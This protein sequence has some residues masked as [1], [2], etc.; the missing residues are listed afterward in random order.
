MP[1]IIFQYN[2][3]DYSLFIITIATLAILAA[4]CGYVLIIDL[5]QKIKHK[6]NNSSLF[7]LLIIF[8]MF[9]GGF[10][11]T[12]SDYTKIIMANTNSNVRTK[13]IVVNKCSRSYR[14]GN[15][16][17]IAHNKIYHLEMP[18]LS[19]QPICQKLGR[20]AIKITYI[21][22]FAYDGLIIKAELGLG[23]P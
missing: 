22:D 5:I 9:F 18:F 20:N 23:Q 4:I 13:I 8:A 17:I 1:E 12:T 19:F 16:T 11:A 21:P 14:G 10:V 7:G 6:P 15:F 2:L 3:Y